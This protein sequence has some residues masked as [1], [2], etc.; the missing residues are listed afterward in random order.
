M[1]SILDRQ[2]PLAIIRSQQTSDVVA[3]GEGGIDPGERDTVSGMA[4]NRS[5][6]LIRPPSCGGM[7]ESASDVSETQWESGPRRRPLLPG[8]K[9]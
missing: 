8:S 2:G 9:T 6:R 5:I 4:K 3:G 7:L 1:D